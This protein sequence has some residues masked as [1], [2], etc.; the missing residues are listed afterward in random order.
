MNT[1]DRTA[2]LR[3]IEET[4]AKGR[5]KDNWESL[6]QY[7]TP[8][9]YENAKFGIFI[10]W[11]IYSVPAFGNEWYSRGMYI[12][13][14]REFEH[15]VATYG[16]QK[17]FGYKD[18][19]PMFRAEKFDADA[20]AE[21][22][23][24]A[25]A[26]YVVPVAEHHDGFQMYKSDLSEWNSAEKGPCRDVLG[27]LKMSCEARGLNLCASSHRIEHWFF[28]GHGRDFDSDI[29]E[30]MALG[31]FYWPAMP[32]PGHQ[33]L[34]SEPTPSREFLEDWLL[35]CCEIV[36]RYSPKLVYFDWWIQHSA[37]K[38]YLQKFAAYYYNRAQEEGYEP[39]ICYK[40]DAFQ[41]GCATVDVERGQFADCKPYFWQTD[42]A[43]A[44]NSWCY[45]DGNRFKDPHDIL[46]DFVDIVSKNGCLLLNVGPRAD[47]TI[48]KED[49]NILLTIGEW[50]EKN[51][52]AVYGSRPWRVSAEGP[53]EIPEGQFT[54]GKRKEFTSEDVRY[55]CRGDSIYAF[56][57]KYPESGEVKFPALG[58]RDAS[59]KPNFHGIIKNVSVLGFDETP[60]WERREDAL[61]I[62][63]KTVGGD[64]PVVFRVTVA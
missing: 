56:V 47:G 7:R 52:E 11:G 41:F 4:I 61:H 5:F 28:M 54:D 64:A 24:R 2:Y 1:A 45:T 40:H 22:F 46:R 32:E 44:Y 39:V 42:T 49:T 33:D 17:D 37:A 21:L 62:R 60:E 57:L 48:T 36:D 43:C 30:P 50:M 53:T 23:R 18:F 16:P 19:I 13:G 34:F 58:E 8:A 26:K 63:T 3:R 59:S 27:E 10:H 9:W 6:S 15:H 38:P 51:G 14:T 35:R 25:G 20:W 55:T 12:E 31:D 29:K